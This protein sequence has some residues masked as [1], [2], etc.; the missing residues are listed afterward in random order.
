MV[1]NTR[2][3]REIKWDKDELHN[4]DVAI[5]QL[6]NLKAAMI[7]DGKSKICTDEFFSELDIKEI[8]KLID[9]LEYIHD[10][11]FLK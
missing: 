6:L 3:V 4:F 11:H 2:V 5:C 9:G 8:D 10:I 7:D 1:L